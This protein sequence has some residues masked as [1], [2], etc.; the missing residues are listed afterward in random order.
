M[1]N[2]IKRI[3]NKIFGLHLCEHHWVT[4][5]QGLCDEQEGKWGWSY[6]KYWIDECDKCGARVRHQTHWP[7]NVDSID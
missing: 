5:K 7:V 2:L 6:Q 4:V 3:L 1:R